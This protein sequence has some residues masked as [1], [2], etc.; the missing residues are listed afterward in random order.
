MPTD[1][2]HVTCIMALTPSNKIHG[3][4]FEKL[5]VC[6]AS[7]EIPCLLWNQ[8]LHYHAHKRPPP[9]FILRHINPTH[10]LKHCSLRSILILSSQLCL[11]LPVVSSPQAFQPILYTLLISPTH[12]TCP[13]HVASSSSI[14]LLYHTHTHTQVCKKKL[15]RYM[16]WRHMGGE[17]V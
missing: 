15:S 8:K 10:T 14:N 16:P 11:G 9:V 2:P 7:Q 4:V 6:S 1:F 13:T 12:A 3:A 5:T 17:E